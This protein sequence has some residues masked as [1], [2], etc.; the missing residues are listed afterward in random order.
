L[1]RSLAIED[2]TSSIDDDSQLTSSGYYGQATVTTARIDGDDGSSPLAAA[3]SL[4]TAGLAASAALAAVAKPLAPKAA[5][6]ATSPSLQQDSLKA[7]AK[8]TLWR[9][10]WQQESI[11][12]ALELADD[13][14]VTNAC[15]D[16][17]VSIHL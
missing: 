2:S 10:E 8:S 5:T 6:T 4:M 16:S 15:N 17:E 11:D 7:G 13:D 1:K 3:A 12:T 9:Q 14:D